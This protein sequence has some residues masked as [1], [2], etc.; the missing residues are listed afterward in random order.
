MK[1]CVMRKQLT[2]KDL[3]SVITTLQVVIAK[4]II[5]SMYF[6]TEALRALV[7]KLKVE[8]GYDVD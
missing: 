2:D 8:T 4:L 6:K 5:S 7:D 3:E 1:G